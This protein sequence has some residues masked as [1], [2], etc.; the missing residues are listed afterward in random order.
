MTDWTRC[1]RNLPIRHKLRLIVGFAVAVALLPA[2]AAI[3][4]FDRIQI[5]ESL[6][7]DLA[8]LAGICGADSAAALS[9]ED[10]RTAEELLA[11]LRAKS[12]IEM[13]VLYLQNGSPLAVYYRAGSPHRPV[14]RPEAG[15]S[16]FSGGR[17]HLFQS[18][19]FRG[20]TVGSIYLE[21]NLSEA[22]VRQKRFS[23][24]V[25]IVLLSSSALAFLVSGRVQKSVSGPI[26]HLASVARTVSAHNNYAVRASKQADDDLGQLIDTF[27]GMLTEIEKR[28]G[29]LLRHRANLELEVSQRTAELRSSNAELLEARDRAEAASLA[30]SQF[31][32]N[33]SHEIRTPMNG[34]MGMSDFLLETALSADQLEFASTVR[35][36]AESLL[37]IINDILDFSKIEAGR[38]ELDP[39]PFHVHDLVEQTLRTLAIQAHEKK[40][41]LIGEVLPGVPD[42]VVTDPMRV[43]QIIMNLTGNAIKFTARGEVTVT[44]RPDQPGYLHF[45]V[46]DTGIGIPPGKHK[47]IF[48]AF[49]QA[50]GSTT[51]RFGGTGLGLTISKR[52]AEAMGGKI[53]LESE[54]GRGSC[55]HFTIGFQ[56]ALEPVRRARPDLPPGLRVLAVDDNATNRRVLT[57]LLRSWS[58]EAEAA[59]TGQ[60]ALDMLSRAAGKGAGYQLILTDVHMPEM[61]GFE[62]VE[63]LRRTENGAATPV[64]MLSSAEHR[65]DKSRSRLAGVTA[66]VTK[67][68]R[69]EELR[70]VM[71]H[72]LPQSGS[73]P[74]APVRRPE[75]GTRVERTGSLV[76]LDI[77]LAEDNAVNQRVALRILEGAGHRVVLASNGREAIELLAGQRFDLVLMDVQM[78]EMD[79]LETARAIRLRETAAGSPGIPIIAMTANAMTGDREHCLEAGMNDYISKPIRARDLLELIAR[80]GSRTAPVA[81]TE[82]GAWR[83]PSY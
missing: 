8:T 37:G 58:V 29:E 38:L 80:I 68:I 47:T 69:R 32:A 56:P 11:G 75:P 46:R 45:E 17:L 64:V 31:L 67:P 72:A 35:A 18:I 70:S 81:P 79:G 26:A 66:F 77:L 33:M 65:G 73:G 43:R 9:F 76:P 24:I 7:R 16:R 5:H 12:S 54:L 2:C 61:D 62:F 6:R 25:L 36:S 19:E 22:N 60:E 39:V 49:S 20:Q 83:R 53:W 82:S 71:A 27:N 51:R 40:I 50:D 55:F 74:A 1:Y 14:P 59:S 10:A 13:A 63:R 78:P 28:D 21:S 15:E 44:V 57:D 30:K 4:A 42:E 41:E 3:L 23:I 48:E 52:L 34:I